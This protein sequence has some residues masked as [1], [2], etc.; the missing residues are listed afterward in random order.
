MP[1]TRIPGAKSTSV[2]GCRVQGVG[3]QVSEVRVQGVGFQVLGFRVQGVEFQVS[4]L[5]VQ[6]LECSVSDFRDFSE[7][8][9]QARKLSPRPCEYMNKVNYIQ[10]P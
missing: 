6:D 4:G 1:W 10:N 2:Q 7:S 9:A 8:Y 5:R 3:F